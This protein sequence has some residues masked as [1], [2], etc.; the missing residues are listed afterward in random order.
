MGEQ[1][2]VSKD[3][4]APAEVAYAMVSDVTRMGE[5]SPEC[6][7]VEWLKESTGPIVGARFRGTNENGKKTWSTDAV[8]ID[9]DPGKRFAFDVHVGPVK[10]ARWS[11]DFVSTDAGCTVTETWTD[12]RN[13][14][15][16][17]L[18]KPLGGVSDRAS[19]NREG[20][21]QTL[22]RLAAAA[23]AEASAPEV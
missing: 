22:D 17:S 10:V 6:K 4:A 20:M 23:K 13:V 11:Y 18:G 15:I 14:L 5:W 16:R 2:E 1:V 21:I 8:I 7:A 3:V 12:R 19:H 9:A